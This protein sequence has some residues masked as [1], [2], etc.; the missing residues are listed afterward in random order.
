[1]VVV[2]ATDDVLVTGQ[3]EG[4]RISTA[5][6]CYLF[7]EDV[8]RFDPGWLACVIGSK[9]NPELTVSVA[10]PGVHLGQRLLF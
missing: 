4:V 7:I 1:M 9:L 8:K 5:Y 2:A 6:L 10:T 3:E